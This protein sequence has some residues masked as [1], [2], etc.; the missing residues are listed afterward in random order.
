MTCL[1]S[2]TGVVFTFIGAIMNN[3]RIH[4]KAMDVNTQRL[5]F[6]SEGVDLNSQISNPIASMFLMMASTG[7]IGINSP[8]QPQFPAFPLEKVV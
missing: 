3:P 7:V 5:D 8:K 6:P 1:R 2:L 4:P